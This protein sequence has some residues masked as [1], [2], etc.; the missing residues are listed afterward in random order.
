MPPIRETSVVIQE[1]LESIHR[2]H[3]A[4]NDGAVAD[5]I[6]ELAQA[7]PAHF[8][9]ALATADGRIDAVGDSEVPFTIQS[10]SK[11]FSYGLALKLLG[12]DHMQ[13]KVG[14]EPSGEAFN[15]ISPDPQTGIPRNPMSNGGAIATTAQI[16]QAMGRTG[17]GC[18]WGSSPIWP[19]GRSASIRRSIAQ[20]ATA[21]IAI[22]RSAICCA[23]PR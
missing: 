19:T 13:R 6:P 23:M 8:G 11:P 1:L 7:D 9:I 22:G 21:A 10:I 2:R 14:V 4:G 20:S 18:C 16:S 12:P 17:N 5:Y 3:S 15:A